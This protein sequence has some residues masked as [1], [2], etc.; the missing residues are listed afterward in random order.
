MKLKTILDQASPV[1]IDDLDR[2]ANDIGPLPQAVVEY[3]LESN[4]GI[5]PKRRLIGPNRERIEIQHLLSIVNT[6]SEN[7]HTCEQMHKILTNNWGVPFSYLPI[8]RDPGGNFFCLNRETGKVVLV[9]NDEEEEIGISDNF[10][11]F[12]GKLTKSTTNH[13]P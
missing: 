10:E 11:T 2:V 12:L 8:A 7:E 3:F 4:G 6:R 5:P 13:I 1:T 9:Y